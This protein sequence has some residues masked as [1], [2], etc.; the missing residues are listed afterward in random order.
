MAKRTS[1]RK[2]VKKEKF[3]RSLP[4]KVD[5]A[6]KADLG[7]KL[8][9]ALKSMRDIEAAKKS[10]N[11]EFKSRLQAAA[12]LADKYSDALQTGK[13]YELVEC[14]A[15]HDGDKATVKVTRLDSGEIIEEREMSGEERQ[16]AFDFEG[17]TGKDA[18]Q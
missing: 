4:V 18:E 8:A 13:S 9:G 3:H 1:K 15:L 14:E 12:A 16:S 17:E 10:A 6:K 11:A 7:L 5:E 2:N